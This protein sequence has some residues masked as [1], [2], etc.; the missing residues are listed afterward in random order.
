MRNVDIAIA[1]HVAV[2]GLG[3]VLTS[4]C[5]GNVAAN[6]QLDAS[7]RSGDASL[8]Q[9]TGGLGDGCEGGLNFVVGQPITPKCAVTT[10]TDASCSLVVA[11]NYNQACTDDTD[12]VAVGQVSTCPAVASDGCPSAAINRNDLTQY[13]NAFSSAIASAPSTS[14][15]SCPAETAP[16]CLRGQCNISSCPQPASN[17]P[18]GTDA[19]PDTQIIPAGS[20]LCSSDF[21]P[22]DAGVSE[23]G[24]VMW[25]VPPQSCTRYN[26][27]W[28]CCMAIG[29]SGAVCRPI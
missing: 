13:M 11:P 1:L 15:G 22:V 18:A 29:G 14:G 17:P 2:A 7:S 10:R 16:C 20:V 3:T 9:D 23:A 27:G 4:G 25:C 19:G 8:P 6:N 24:R 12:C 5:G 21:G 28:A 26:G